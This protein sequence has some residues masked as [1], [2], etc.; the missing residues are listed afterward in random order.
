MLDRGTL[1]LEQRNEFSQYLPN[2][3]EQGRSF[4]I[5]GSQTEI[6]DSERTVDVF[7][8][9]EIVTEERRQENE[10]LESITRKVVEPG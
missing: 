4:P 8:R 2:E 9:G 1:H 7:S 10:Q 5:R 6:S 3:P